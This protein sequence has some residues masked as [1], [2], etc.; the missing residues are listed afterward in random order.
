[1]LNAFEA[2]DRELRNGNPLWARFAPQVDAAQVLPAAIKAGV[3]F[4]PGAAFFADN[5]EHNT[6]RLSYSTVDATSAEMG[7]ARLAQA[8]RASC[9]GVLPSATDV[10]FQ[11]G[12]HAIDG[13]YLMVKLNPLSIA[14]RRIDGRLRTDLRRT[15][16][17]LSHGVQARG[18][19]GNCMKHEKPNSPSHKR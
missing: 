9:N 10:L 12:E 2:L 1:V 17:C 8:L 5:P 11:T 7:A 16:I 19:R 3:T 18:N 4:V 13:H 6:L 14:E 15:A